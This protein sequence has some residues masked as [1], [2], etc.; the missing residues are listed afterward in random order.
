VLV[1][2]CGVTVACYQLRS[3]VLIRPAGRDPP[4]RPVVR[5][6]VVS[7]RLVAESYR[8]WRFAADSERGVAFDRYFA[9]L[10]RE[11][12][13]AGGYRRVVERAHAA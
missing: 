13:V 12:D 11:E 5:A 9:A 1:G 4:S 6:G 8:T 3:D 2:P 10:D 7:D